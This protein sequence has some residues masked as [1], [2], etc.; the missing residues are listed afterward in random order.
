VGTHL[1]LATVELDEAA[2]W[3]EQ[4]LAHDGGAQGR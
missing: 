3:E 2:V 4:L 1:E